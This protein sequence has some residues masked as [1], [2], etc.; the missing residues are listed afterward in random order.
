MM[1]LN[2]SEKTLNDSEK[3]HI[4]SRHKNQYF[5]VL[6]QFY[7]IYTKPIRE[8]C[9][10]DRRSDNKHIHPGSGALILRGQ[11]VRFPEI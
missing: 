5:D 10:F 2:D 4:Y 8:C 9:Q 3:K 11:N 7:N 1:M 6:A